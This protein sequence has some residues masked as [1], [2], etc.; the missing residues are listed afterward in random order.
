MRR[1]HTYYLKGR[2]VQEA[3]ERHHV[4][5]SLVAEQLGISRSYWSQLVNRRRSLTPAVRTRMLKSRFFR[6]MSESELWD[7]VSAEGGVVCAANGIDRR[8]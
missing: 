6:G 1:L 7:V 4:S 8:R 3:A 5:L 2:T